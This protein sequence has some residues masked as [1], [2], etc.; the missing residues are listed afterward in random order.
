MSLDNEGEK[1]AVIC[2]EMLSQ[3]SQVG[4]NFNTDAEVLDFITGEIGTGINASSFFINS[5]CPE[6]YDPSCI[7]QELMGNLYGNVLQNYMRNRLIIILPILVSLAVLSLT[8]NFLGIRAVASLRDKLPRHWL[9]MNL[10]VS[11][12]SLAAL[13][14]GKVSAEIF[15]YSQF[16]NLF[17]DY[18]N[19]AWQ[20]FFLLCPFSLLMMAIDNVIAVVAPFFYNRHSNKRSVIFAAVFTLWCILVVLIL[21]LHIGKIQ[22]AATVQVIVATLILLIISV[23]V[24]LYI[25]LAM[26][27]EIYRRK[28]LLIAHPSAGESPSFFLKYFLFHRI[29]IVISFTQLPTEI[30]KKENC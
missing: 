13:N 1:L 24:T 23:A 11:D 12:A 7:D 4:I 25:A 21:S 30:S 14:V 20:F 10:S 28:L 6:G 2:H 3:L 22:H 29:F 8:S 16:D 27:A 18:F 19:A 17:R 26:K 9:L 15:A 5:T